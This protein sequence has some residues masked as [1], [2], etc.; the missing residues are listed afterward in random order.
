MFVGVLDK[1]VF[2]LILGLLTYFDELSIYKDE[3][4]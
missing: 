3:Y 2:L 4:R 1:P